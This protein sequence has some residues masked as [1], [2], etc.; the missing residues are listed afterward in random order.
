MKVK[1]IGKN[2]DNIFNVFLNRNINPHDI[3]RLDENFLHDPRLM[4]NLLEAV[5]VVHKHLTETTGKI[6]IVQDP[7]ADGYTSLTS[8][9][10]YFTHCFGEDFKKRLIVLIQEGKQH[11][12]PQKVAD[13]IIEEHEVS[14]IIAPD[15]SSN[16]PETH[17]KYSEMGIDVVVLDHHPAKDF[18]PYA[19]MV[20]PSLDDYP[21]KNLSGVGVCQKF[22]KLFDEEYGFDFAD[23]LYDLVAI[24]MVAD[25][26]EINT[27]ET[28]Y[29]VQR[30][31]RET[32]NLFLRTL[33]AARSYNLGSQITPVGISFVVAPMFNAV[34]RVGTMEEKRDLVFAMAEQEPIKIPSG[35]R[36]AKEGDTE[37]I[38]G[39]M[40]R[41]MVNIKSRQD[42]EKKKAVK[43]MLS[44]VKDGNMEENQI[45]ILDTNGDYPAT[46]TGLIANEFMK[47]YGKPTL[48][49]TS[50]KD[51]ETG[52]LYFKGSARGNDKSDLDELKKFEQD[53]GLFEYAEGHEA[54]HGFSF[55]EDKKDEIVK[56][57]NEELK[58]VVLD[59]VWEVDFDIDY[60]EMSIDRMIEITKYSTYWARGLDEPTFVLRN[61]PITKGKVEVG[62]SFGDHSLRFQVGNM[63]FIKFNGVPTEIASKFNKNQQTLVDIVGKVNMNSYKGE[64]N[65]QTIIQDIEVKEAKKYVF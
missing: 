52:K 4:K 28:I 10:V 29:M 61:V 11:E 27:F 65:L 19:T 41:R 22:C 6:L 21:N 36:G 63:H 1:L 35:K 30:G 58:D 23:E 64:T 17:K 2:E 62:G 20:N 7:D 50:Y 49:G 48:V 18:S 25:M 9:I 60:K 16:E 57:F 26:I 47:T 45:L 40:V 39:N 12:I 43:E 54:A 53:S 37:T 59:P 55:E 31:L 34:A 15:C 56:Y 24:G 42:R 14:L 44:Q 13:K 33:Y 51:Q 8:L 32:K 3:V 38:Q 46:F 5:Y